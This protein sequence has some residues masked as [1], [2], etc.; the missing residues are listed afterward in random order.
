MSA[1]EPTIQFS[2][3]E[4]KN[5]QW[6]PILDGSYSVSSLGRIRR[7]TYYR[8]TFAGRIRKPDLHPHGYL[9]ILIRG[10]HYF[11]HGLVA[12]AFIGP[13]PE[14]FQ[15]NHK[16]AI[17]TD[18]RIENLE[19]VTISH[20]MLHATSLGIFPH[21]DTHH[22]HVWASQRTYC[23]KGH[24]LTPENIVKSRG[25]SQCK[26]CVNIARRKRRAMGK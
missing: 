8:N 18:N 17:K 11:I 20:N 1:K 4:L 24:E 25:I 22:N 2:E 9:R 10:H 19:Y 6:R 5:E 16:N 12:E 26:V 14:K 21:G 3:E 7:N 13:K 15:V 23:S